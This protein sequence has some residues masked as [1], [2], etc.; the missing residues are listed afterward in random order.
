M[1]RRR[2]SEAQ[3]WQIIRMRSSGLSYKAIGRQMGYHYTVASRLVRKRIQ[4]NNVKDLPRSGRPFVTSQREDRALQRLV[5]R[6]PFAT[7]PVLKREWLPH[8]QLST[9]TLRNRLK[10]AGLKS[11]SVIRRPMLPDRH[12]QLRLAWYLI[13]RG[14]NLRNWPKI[15]WSDESRFGDIKIQHI[16]QETS[17]QLSLTVEAL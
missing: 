6:M 9:R 13:R 8:R 11:R 17:K 10:S 15:Y 4:T 14:W 7:S 1:V 12:Q 2:R 5:R 16:P 3:R